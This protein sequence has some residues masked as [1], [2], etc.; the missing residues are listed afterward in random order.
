MTLGCPLRGCNDSI[1]ER[2]ALRT[3]C[4]ASKGK[5]YSEK[6]KQKK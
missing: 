6:I 2:I 1:T 3:D 5:R 4:T